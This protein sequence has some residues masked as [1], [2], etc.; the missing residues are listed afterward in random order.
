MLL[1]SAID[2]GLHVAVMD[3]DAAA[4]CRRYTGSFTHADPLDYDA[5]LR[6]GEGLDF[7]TIEK[8]AVNVDALETLAG[9]GVRVRPG[10]GLV[11]IIQDKWVQ[12]EAL[13][14]AG[15]PVVPGVLI[16]NRAALAA[17]DTSSAACLKLCR[18]GYD[19]YGVQM[20]R[21]PEDYTRGFDA[22]SVLEELV[23]IEKEL[24]VIVARAAAGQVVHYDPVEMVADPVRHLLAYQ[25]CPAD[26]SPA[27]AEEAVAL[28]RR[29][30]E[31]LDLVGL[32]AVELFLTKEGKVLVNELAP[33][34]HNSGHHTIEGCNTSQFEQLWRA[35]LDW[36]LGDTAIRQPSAMVNLLMPEGG[37]QALDAQVRQVVQTGGAHLHLYGKSGGKPGRKMGHVT[38]TADTPQA[39][40]EKASGI[41]AIF[42]SN[43]IS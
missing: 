35:V 37:Q 23:D 11:R 6:F 19:G 28:A 41:R 40:L 5:V 38:L 20:L 16:E 29:T 4:P 13:R 12:K 43:T 25:L 34:P 17:Q 15:L 27:I 7:L 21:T 18:G 2:L 33:R 31:A 22:P 14:A 10:G 39:A 30:A 8:E 24:S 26:I 42:Q 9:R 32:M 36:P 3:A 1:R